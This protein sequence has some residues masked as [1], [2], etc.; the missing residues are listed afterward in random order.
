MLPHPAKKYKR[1][2]QAGVVIGNA[3]GLLKSKIG[4]CTRSSNQNYRS[5]PAPLVLLTAKRMIE[6]PAQKSQASCQKPK[7]RQ[8][9]TRY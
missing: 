6:F 4:A 1:F 2:G 8:R 9:L 7:N 5:F 3:A